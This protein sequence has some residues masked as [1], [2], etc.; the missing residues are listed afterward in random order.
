M[1]PLDTHCVLGLWHRDERD[2][3]PDLRVHRPIGQTGPG[4]LEVG[5]Q[6][7]R[8]PSREAASHIRVRGGLE[9]QRLMGQE[10]PVA[11]G[12]LHMPGSR[13]VG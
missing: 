1:G 8:G 6:A 12:G 5:V 7:A 11:L 10:A 2:P 13:G 3:G 4:T 9:G